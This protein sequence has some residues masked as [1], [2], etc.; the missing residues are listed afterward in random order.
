[1]IEK[2]LKELR[3]KAGKSQY[4]LADESGV[5]REQIARIEGGKVGCNVETFEKLIKAL[6]YKLKVVK[7]SM[8]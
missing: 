7:V 3:E 6:G 2:C 8:R 5:R 4:Q 1:M